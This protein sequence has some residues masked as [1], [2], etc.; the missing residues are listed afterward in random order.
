MTQAESDA[1][2]RNLGTLEAELG[3]FRGN[4]LEH[5]IDG[6]HSGSA[7]GATFTNHTPIDNSPINEVAAGGA[8]EI[9]LAAAL[10]TLCAV[11]AQKGRVLLGEVRAKQVQHARPL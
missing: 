4:P 3:R 5:L 9:D 11:D 7:S 10:H 6:K 8:G 1:L 2:T